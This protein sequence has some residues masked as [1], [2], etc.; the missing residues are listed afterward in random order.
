[1]SIEPI[2][3]AT[4]EPLSP[5]R[6]P[7]HLLVVIESDDAGI[8]TADR[9]GSLAA[10]S[11]CALTVVL[12]LQLHWGF[13]LAALAG[14]VNPAMDDV[15]IDAVIHLSRTLERY[16]VSWHLKTVVDDPVACVA[17]LVRGRPVRWV[18]VDRHRGLARWRPPARVARALERR[19]GLPV[20]AI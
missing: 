14:I 1:M 17:H 3:P 18:L 15:E 6:S 4:A 10:A 9:A 20:R 12:I 19:H 8:A 11:G 7:G 2:R 16:G 13:S 5:A